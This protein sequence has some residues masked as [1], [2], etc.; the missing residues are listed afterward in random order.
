MQR[1]S[2]LGVLLL[3]RELVRRVGLARMKNFC[4]GKRLISISKFVCKSFRKP[5]G[6]NCIPKKLSENISFDKTDHFVLHG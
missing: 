4:R 6:E 5:G 3:S 1:T 2:P